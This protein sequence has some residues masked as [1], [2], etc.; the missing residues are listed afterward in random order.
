MGGQPIVAL[1][2]DGVFVDNLG[3]AFRRILR[4]DSPINQNLLVDVFKGVGFQVLKSWP[5]SYL[6]GV[7]LGK[8][9]PRKE[10]LEIFKAAQASDARLVLITYNPK[11]N[12]QEFERDAAKNY[13]LTVKAVYVKDPLKKGAA[14]SSMSDGSRVLLI[15]DDAS[16][17]LHA[18]ENGVHSIIVGEGHSRLGSKVA[19]MMNGYVH[20]AHNWG[21]AQALASKFLRSEGEF[22]LQKQKSVSR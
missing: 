5:F 2:Y 21:E 15:D 20:R 13:D 17:A 18:A 19:S 9:E 4:L 12:L 1:D 8:F 16:I 7:N 11:L 22:S 3:N 6:A 14:L 10:A